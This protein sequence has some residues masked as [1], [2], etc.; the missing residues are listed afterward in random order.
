MFTLKIIDNAEEEAWELLGQEPEKIKEFRKKFGLKNDEQSAERI[1]PLIKKTPEKT[2]KYSEIPELNNLA[3]MPGDKETLKKVMQISGDKD[4]EKKYIDLMKERDAREKRKRG[5]N[6]NLL[7]DKIKS[8]EYDRPVLLKIDNELF[9]IGGRTRLYAALALR[10]D[11]IVKI[12]D[13]K[14]FKGI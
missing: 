10:I 8:G 2:I 12:L 9:V 1:I 5:Y 11:P 3:N 13:D 6:V 7:V 4:A 14:L